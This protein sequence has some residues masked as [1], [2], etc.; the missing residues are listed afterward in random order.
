MSAKTS[1]VRLMIGNIDLVIYKFE[2]HFRASSARWALRSGDTNAAVGRS[3]HTELLDEGSGRYV[4]S[5][6]RVGF[7]VLETTSTLAPSDWLP[8][9]FPRFVDCIYIL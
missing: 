5:G 4:C 1:K 2:L 3:A 7:G 6:E 8:S 9:S